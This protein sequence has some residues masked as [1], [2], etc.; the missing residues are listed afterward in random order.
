M[1][2]NRRRYSSLRMLTLLLGLLIAFCTSWLPPTFGVF[3]AL[4]TAVVYFGINGIVL[5]DW[6]HWI[7]GAAGPLVAIV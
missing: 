1:V 7:V 4:V 2:A 5:F 3:T 6:G